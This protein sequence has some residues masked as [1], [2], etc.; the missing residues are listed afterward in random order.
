MC[1]R[2]GSRSDLPFRHVMCEFVFGKSAAAASRSYFM[3]RNG[4]Q[5]KCTHE[6]FLN[7]RIGSLAAWIMNVSYAGAVK[8][9]FFSF[10]RSPVS[11]SLVA[12]VADVVVVV[13]VL[14]LSCGTTCGHKYK[15]PFIIFVCCGAARFCV[16]ELNCVAQHSLLF[17][18]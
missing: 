17:H 4:A 12:R 6:S 15:M 10:L 11:S 8:N 3:Y 9:D 13:A 7:R 5:T 16:E 2:A 1:V 18:A 14:A